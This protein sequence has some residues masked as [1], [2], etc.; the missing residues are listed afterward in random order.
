MKMASSKFNGS[1]T[2]AGKSEFRNQKPKPDDRGKNILNGKQL[3]AVI[4]RNV[5][6]EAWL[7][8]LSCNS[9][10]SRSLAGNA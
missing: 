8:M 1:A 7:W 2:P 3:R 6:T 9:I 4:K 10:F 5:R